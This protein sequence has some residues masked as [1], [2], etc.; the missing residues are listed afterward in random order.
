MTWVNLNKSKFKA[1][2]STAKYV[3]MLLMINILPSVLMPTSITY[4]S[5]TVIDHSY[6]NF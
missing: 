3:D 2:D 5:A 1:N 4:E 6:Y